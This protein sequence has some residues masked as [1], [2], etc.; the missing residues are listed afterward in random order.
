LAPPASVG[1]IGALVFKYTLA[2]RVILLVTAGRS[3]ASRDI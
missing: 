2:K 3:Q 1:G